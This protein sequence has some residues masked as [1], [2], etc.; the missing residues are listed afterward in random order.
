[1]ARGQNTVSVYICDN[2][3]LNIPRFSWSAPYSR[4][5]NSRVIHRTFRMKTKTAAALGI[6]RLYHYQG[7]EKPA[8]WGS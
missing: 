3:V 2:C 5:V 6:K 7:F 1:M 4:A 8:I